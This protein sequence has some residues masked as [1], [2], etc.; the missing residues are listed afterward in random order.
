MLIL[1]IE[2]SVKTCS[3]AI[4]KEGKL[5][6][7]QESHPEGFEHSE[8]LNNFIVELLTRNDFTL[9]HLKAIAVSSGPGSYTGLRIGAATAKGLCYALDIP[10]IAIDALSI[11]M[12]KFKID[13]PEKKADYFIPM[14]DARRMEVYQSVYDGNF[15]LI[16]SPS[17]NVIDENSFSNLNGNVILFGEGADKLTEVLFTDNISI[18]SNFTTS[19]SGMVKL[20]FDKYSKKDFEDVA[21]FDPIYLKEFKAG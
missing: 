13:F 1:H 21:Y 20:S 16:E 6:D 4:A 5:I 10:L 9:A 15:T 19:S 3:V 7:V 11:M 18:I 8:S 14:I 12:E 2:T 17:A